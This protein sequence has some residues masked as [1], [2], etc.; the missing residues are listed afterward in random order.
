MPTTTPHVSV[1]IPAYNCASF[2]SEALESVFS[3]TFTDYE[4]IVVEDGSTDNTYEILEQYKEKIH[5]LQQE[6]AG[7]AAARNKGITHSQGEF[8]AFLDAD[9]V[10]SHNK[11]AAHMALFE[12]HPEL[13]ITISGWQIVDASG[14]AIS[15]VSPWQTNPI[16]NLECAVLI[17]PARPS[18]T[19][20]RR[21]I[22]E[23][24]KQFDTTLSSGEDLDLLLRLLA[25]GVQASWL[26]EILIN[27]RQHSDSL[28]TQGRQLLKDTETVMS[29]FFARTDLPA[30]IASLHRQE[31]YQS[32]SWLAAKMYY[33]GHFAESRDCL[34]EALTYADAQDFSIITEW[35]QVF[36]GYAAEYGRSFDAYALTNAE[37]WKVLSRQVVAP[38]TVEQSELRSHPHLINNRKQPSNSLS[39]RA[40]PEKRVLLYSDD[41][42]A[43]GVLHCNHAIVCHL[44]QSGYQVSH[45]CFQ[46]DTPLFEQESL[47]GVQS[48]DL[49][50]HSGQ[51]AVRSRLDIQGARQLF[52]QHQPSLVI[53]SDGWPFSNLAAKQAAIDLNIPFVIVLGFIEPSC[54]DFAP[55]SS[56]N[57]K[58]LVSIQ[59]SRAQEVI[60][61]SENNLQ[62]LRQ[63]FS[64]PESVG[65][66]IYN[67]RPQTYFAKPATEG[68][69]RYAREQLRQEFNI[70][71]DGIVCFTSGRLEPVK[72]YQHQIEAMR[73][74]KQQAVWEKLWFVW[75]GVGKEI[76]SSSNEN[77]LRAAAAAMGVTDRVVFLGQRWDIPQWLEASDIFVLTSEAE[78]MPLSVMEA[79]AKGLPV[80]ATA[81]SGVPEELGET[82]RLISDPKRDAEATVK[83]LVQ[84]I[85]IW[86]R[87]QAVRKS[88]GEDCR[89]RATQLFQEAHML[90]QYE[91]TVACVLQLFDSGCDRRKEQSHTLSTHSST[92]RVRNQHDWQIENALRY[93]SWLWTAWSC[94]V[95]EDI[96][97]MDSALE[98]ALRSPAS[99]QDWPV[100]EWGRLFAYFCGQ[101]GIVFDASKLARSVV[102]A[103]LT[104]MKS[105]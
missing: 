5:I 58:A 7:V 17:K 77:A 4:V 52:E 100:L 10:F 12:Q 83:E 44:Q 82:G 32:L 103:R 69:A 35:F 65:K 24:V 6:N 54:I 78:G 89:E 96:E 99:P 93:T 30:N 87:S 101:K 81:V 95:S 21:K 72:G 13:D 59:Y 38:W 76:L 61:V 88:I 91:A 41:P 22:F 9:D 50:Y 23:Q 64:L 80:V 26:P 57:Y 86:A 34:T 31:R 55:P 60:C 28:M 42:G 75:A 102:W 51:D 105:Y 36:K 70:P 46:Q 20:L 53:F 14:G 48:I 104:N 85:E 92:R 79:M 45:A 67:G 37:F 25:A 49:G 18:A 3:Q 97:G 19:V 1:I 39:N 62:L 40:E 90:K 56:I 43:G 29:R 63:L 33:G 15:A 11:L 73:Y 68:T 16:L 47:L 98:Q 2:I 27:Y 74:L 71:S 84:T 8:I 94:Y 66:V